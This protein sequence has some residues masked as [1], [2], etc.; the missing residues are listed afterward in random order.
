MASCTRFTDLISLDE[1]RQIN[2][3]AVRG[4][5]QMF[6]DGINTTIENAI[7]K[8]ENGCILCRYYLLPN[9][10]IPVMSRYFIH[11]AQNAGLRIVFSRHSQLHGGYTHSEV[12]IIGLNQLEPG[13]VP[14]LI[15]EP[16][17]HTG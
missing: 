12:S 16:I 1:A 7:S 2:L 11:L 4:N 5:L 14:K 6:I 9:D 10:I 8:G 17:L 3:P 13:V 15:L